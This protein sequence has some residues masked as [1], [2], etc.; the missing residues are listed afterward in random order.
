MEAGLAL[1]D[2]FGR[3]ELAYLV[4]VWVTTFDIQLA[5]QVFI[6]QVGAGITAKPK[7][8]LHVRVRFLH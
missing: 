8:G 5:E 3:A 6:P 7:G 2:R 4:I 1:G